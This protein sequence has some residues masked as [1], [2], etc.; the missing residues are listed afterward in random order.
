MKLIF[1]LIA[2]VIIISS[3]SNYSFCQEN[4]ISQEDIVEQKIKSIRT[5]YYQLSKQG[6]LYKL[7]SEK[8]SFN[9][10]GKLAERVEYDKSD[11]PITSTQFQYDEGGNQSHQR[12]IQHQVNKEFKVSWVNTYEND[13]I[14]KIENSN[15]TAIK[16]FEYDALGKLLSQKDIDDK[17]KVFG[18]KKY[19]YDA[20][21]NLIQQKE[22]L[23]YLERTYDYTYNEKGQKTRTVLTRK[24]TFEG[25]T[26]IQREDFSYDNKGRLGKTVFRNASGRIDAFSNFYYDEVGNLLKEEKGDILYLYKY[27]KLGNLVEKKK[28]VRGNVHLLEK[29][30]YEF[31]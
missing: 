2:V 16:T 12:L 19:I 8:F 9:Q 10:S 14:V 31:W 25:G 3:L 20:S 26:T 24:N 4:A 13:R 11:Q 28:T 15:T 21:G 23:D 27:D 6:K 22:L 17:E 30:M 7:K 1:N 18:E 29:K 5:S